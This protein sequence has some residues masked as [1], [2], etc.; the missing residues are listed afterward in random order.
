MNQ[1]RTVFSQLIAFLPDR[2]F[3][4][5]VARC[6]GDAR[7]RDFSCWN[8]C[9]TMAFAQLTYRESLRDMEACLRALGS[10]VYHMV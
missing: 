2:E 6:E 5:C 1:V 7:L 9:L 3:R 4:R 10:K 8:Q